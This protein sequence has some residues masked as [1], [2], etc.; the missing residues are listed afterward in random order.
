MITLRSAGLGLVAAIVLPATAYAGDK[1]LY[2]PVPDWVVPAP[3]L[4]L[5]KLGENAPI[6]LVF[7][8]QQRLQ[9]GT[10]SAYVDTATRISSPEVMGRFGTIALPWMPDKGDLIV[11]SLEILRTGETIDLLKGEKFQV[12]RREQ[13]LER[14]VLDG[15]LTATLAVEGLRI[16]DILR[17]R[18]T[19]TNS[20]TALK[21]QVQTIAPVPA[22][23]FRSQFA[24]VRMS[25]PVAAPV[26]WRTYVEGATLTPKDIGGYRTI[27][28]PLPVAKQPELPSDAPARFQR[29]P[30]L[31]AA[32]FAD[33]AAVSTTMAPLYG[34]TGTIPVGSPLAAEVAKIA[35]AESDPRRRAAAALQVVQEQVR[36]LALGMNGGNYAPQS[37]V[38]TWELRYGDC[39]A[40]TLM[41]LA[42]LRDLGVTAEA[43]LVASEMGDLV[44]VRLP[45]PAAF[46][47]VIVRAEIDG[48]SYW[49][50][51]TSLGAR[52]ADI[53][54]TPNFRYALPVK[55]A[56]AALMPLTTHANARPDVVVATDY[57]Q[58]AGL[59]LPALFATKVQ[60]RGAAASMLNAG[61]EQASE[62]ER[63]EVL[64]RLVRDR[65]G[66]AQV[67]ES[68]LSYDPT[69]GIATIAAKGFLTT[70]WSREDKRM[71][72]GLDQV[73]DRVSFD[74]D[75][76]RP[77]WRS[78][79]VSTGAP[80]SAEYKVTMRLPQNG[81]GFVLEGDQTL[82]T[83]LAGVAIARTAS[84]AGDIV[85]VEERGDA[86]GVEIAPDAI[87]GERS[88]LALAQRRSLRAVAPADLPPRWRLVR[89][90]PRTAFAA[91]DSAMG[92]AIAL[93]VAD[94]P[95]E[96]SGYESRL[97]FRR[98][99]YDYRAAIDDA[100]KLLAIG[101]TADRLVSRSALYSTVGE[102]AKA[103][104]DAEAAAKLDPGSL[105]AVARL[106][107]A[108]A[109]A[110]RMVAGMARL[111]DRIDQGGKDRF[112]LIMTKAEL[113][114][115]SGDAEGAIAL[116]D[117][118]LVEK[119]GDPSLLNSRCWVKGTTGRSL[120]TALKDC[121]KAIELADS[122]VAALD[123]RAMVYWKMNRPEDAIADLDAAL[124]QAPAQ[125]GSLYL[126]GVIRKKAGNAAGAADDLSG[127]RLIEP[128]IDKE[129]ARFGVTP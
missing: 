55:L 3:P 13:Q 73:V 35:K 44:P 70:Q 27:E 125:A 102:T 112:A 1:P 49:L 93:L 106:A 5:T 88:K 16:G 26:K 9:D 119:P 104:A 4:D 113:Q 99:I 75:R 7:D 123:S 60:M 120:D 30:I 59:E 6:I 127:A 20:D 90:G 53:G 87:S 31:E 96:T 18:V 101:E 66:D 83:S 51:G 92:K 129:Y 36:Y 94:D 8:N 21:G 33:W 95:T 84:L 100:T 47:H 115:R 108:E 89:D 121:T 19:V 118:A 68:Q 54:D 77:A 65:L 61:Y 24:R 107:M 43:V 40:K 2:R 128:L 98:G 28:L 82:A 46:D 37:P 79:P 63:R 14:R 34:T 110:G 22:E 81:R 56:G 69:A 57:D 91:I 109:D 58:T 10:V 38:R 111:T 74:P 78:I 105:S 50:D 126:R 39:K 124:D 12:L 85:T 86:T 114:A 76:S 116:L 45:A 71:K 25:W 64:L 17:M 32:S 23:P 42:M 29:L 97:S 103:L 80:D 72:M 48:R 122:A 11:H 52:L 62:K 41:L 67:T 117:A 15:T